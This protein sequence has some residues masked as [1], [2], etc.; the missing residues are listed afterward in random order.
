MDLQL[1]PAF[2]IGYE[3]ASA[4]IRDIRKDLD[5]PSFEIKQQL[6]RTS[7]AALLIDTAG[8]ELAKKT[9]GNNL[10]FTEDYEAGAALAVAEWID[11]L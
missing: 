4:L 10:E 8:L 7:W 9:L 5:I 2:T 3:T 6:Q 11:H 1:R